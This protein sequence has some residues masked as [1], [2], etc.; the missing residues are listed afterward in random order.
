MAQDQAELRQKL[1]FLKGLARKGTWRPA[2]EAPIEL[3]LITVDSPDVVEFSA[4]SNLVRYS[5]EVLQTP[6][7]LTGG[8]FGCF[9][10]TFTA[11]SDKGR[12]LDN[13]ILSNPRFQYLL[14]DLNTHTAIVRSQGITRTYCAFYELK[15]ALATNRQPQAG[16]ID[17]ETG[18]TDLFGDEAGQGQGQGMTYGLA[19]VEVQ[20]LSKSQPKES[21]M[22]RVWRRISSSAGEMRIGLGRIIVRKVNLFE[23][24]EFQQMISGFKGRGLLLMVHGYANSFDD[25]MKSCARSV[26]KTKIDKLGLLPVL[27]SWPSRGK[28]V[29]YLPDT[30]SAEDSEFALHDLLNLIAHASENREIDIL[31]HS[32]GNKILVRSLC[33]KR[34]GA[35]SDPLHLRRLILIEPDVGQNFLNERIETLAASSEQII[36]YHS[37]NDRALMFAEFL[38]GKIR[39]GQ[40]GVVANGPS[41][42]PDRLEVIDASLVAAGLSKHAPHVEASEVISDIH[43]LLRGIKP[44]N[45]F[46]LRDNGAGTGHWEVVPG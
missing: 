11:K 22:R 24:A 39:A 36:I 8:G 43:H 17:Q 3:R 37:R 10:L 34:Y 35:D 19:E 29:A 4:V 38:F 6:F 31:A 26:Y 15:V 1:D 18:V 7:E 45:R 14:D 5:S 13:A 46:N 30:A 21:L 2:P 16:M 25:A 42:T 44:E 12:D 33:S 20:D 28:T 23:K 40:A 32:H 41:Q 27:F 9:D